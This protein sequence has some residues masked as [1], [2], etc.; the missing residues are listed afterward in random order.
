MKGIAIQSQGSGPALVLF[1]GWGFE[2]SI[3][4]A[5]AMALSLDMKII[6]VDLPGHG[7]TELMP[8]DSFADTLLP[9]LPNAFSVLGW[10]LGGL[11]AL[12]FAERV[13]AQIVNLFLVTSSP[14]FIES[15]QWP[16]IEKAVFERFNMRYQEHPRETVIDFLRLQGGRTIAKQYTP[17]VGRD[18]QEGLTLLQTWDLRQSLLSVECNKYCLLGHR[19][20]IVPRTLAPSLQALDPSIEIEV[21]RHSAHMPFVSQFDNFIRYIQERML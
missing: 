12:N 16:G 14:Y 13:P 1:H 17:I 2:R 21:W 11:Y 15:P 18:M 7:G 3:W 4:K 10:S 9:L 5:C 19:D 20:S 6:T 8:A